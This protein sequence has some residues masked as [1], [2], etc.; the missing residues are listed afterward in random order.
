MI[1]LDLSVDFWSWALEVRRLTLEVRRLTLET[2]NKENL[3][4]VTKI[5]LLGFHEHHTLRSSFFSILVAV[6]LLTISGNLVLIVL[7]SSSRHL[8]IPMYIFLTQVSICDMVLTTTIMPRMISIV[9]YNG[10]VM[11]LAA[12]ITQYNFFGG[13]EASECFLLIAMSYD[14]YLVIC[15]PLR[16]NLIMDNECCITLIIMSWLSGLSLELII[17]VAVAQLRFCGPNTIDHFFCDFAPLLQL[18]CSDTFIVQ[19]QA[20]FL[21]VPILI[22]PL[23][24]IML[25]YFYIVITIVKIPSISGRQKAFSTFS[26]HLAVVSIFYGTLISM[27]A[28][29]RK[30]Q[31]MS[32]RKVLSLFYTVV[33]PMLNPIIYSLRN[34]DIKEALKKL[35]KKL[36]Q[37][38]YNTELLIPRGLK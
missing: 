38:L 8:N 7:V 13:S 36:I 37:T 5:R 31:S 14:R 9:L 29:P 26:S 18:S 30:K 24:I 4:L 10:D 22:T 21:C 20:L 34:Q 35:K 2:M 33:T 27:Y 1:L 19:M 15:H 25:S 28:V 3:I 6:Y 32:V 23:V 16:Y 17:T 11:S 12:C